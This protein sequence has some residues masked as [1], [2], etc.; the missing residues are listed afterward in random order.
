MSESVY[1]IVAIELGEKIMSAYLYTLKTA[2]NLVINLRNK[3]KNIK[4][5]LKKY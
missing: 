5:Y 4:Y 2:V 3:N 1:E